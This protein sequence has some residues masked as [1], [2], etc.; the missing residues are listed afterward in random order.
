MVIQERKN[1]PKQKTGKYQKVKT[2]TGT[3]G[4][5]RISERKHLLVYQIYSDIL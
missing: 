4:W 3:T 5:N 1:Y 2:A